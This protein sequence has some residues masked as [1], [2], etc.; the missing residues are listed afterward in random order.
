MRKFT[1]PFLGDQ[2]VALQAITMQAATGQL[3]QLKANSQWLHLTITKLMPEFWD[4][5]NS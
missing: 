2:P 3:Q 1:T 4:K 5:L